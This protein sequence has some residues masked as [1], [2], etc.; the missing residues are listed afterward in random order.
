MAYAKA[1]GSI[2]IHTEPSVADPAHVLLWSVPTTHVSGVIGGSGTL[3]QRLLIWLLSKSIY[4]QVDQDL[5]FIE[6]NENK[7]S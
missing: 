1:S 6:V 5:R 4:N 3:W 2:L 7:R